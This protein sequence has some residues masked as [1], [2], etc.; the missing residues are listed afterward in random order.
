[1]FPAAGIAAILGVAGIFVGGA[2][3]EGS[4]LPGLYA[5]HAHEMVFG[6]GGGA[7]AAYTLTAMRSWSETGGL[8]RPGIVLLF[9]L[10]VASRLVAVGAFGDKPYVNV[11]AGSGFLVFV[12]IS[13]GWAALRS[14]SVTGGLQ[15]V[16][17]LTLASFQVALLYG[18]ALRIAPVLVMV[19]LLSVIGG[20][21]VTAFTWN[22]IRQTPSHAQRFKM[23]KILGAVSACTLGAT[24]V[25]RWS[26]LVSGGHVYAGVLLLCA[27]CELGRL[28]LWQSRDVWRDGMLAMLHVAFAWLPVGLSLLAAAQIVPDLISERDALHVLTVGAISS[29][30]YAVAARAIAFRSERLR[31]ALA[32]LLGFGLLSAAAVLRFLSDDLIASAGAVWTVCWA[33]F[34]LRHWSALYRPALRPVFSGPAKP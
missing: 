19:L 33:V 28:L 4:P 8:S 9:G 16:F 32:D 6:F 2:F 31:P 26:D 24:T 27:A 25:L 22:R 1:M 23:A 13:L 30:I 12:S 11:P 29:A 17:A 5:W 10:W 18:I 3:S 34:F 14:R 20:R 7:L 15:A 21:M